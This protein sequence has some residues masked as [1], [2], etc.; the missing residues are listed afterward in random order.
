MT[1]WHLIHLGHLALS[2][3]ALL[4]IEATAVLPEGQVTFAEPNPKQPICGEELKTTFA[5]PPQNAHRTPKG[6][7]L[8]FQGGT[9]SNTEEE[10]GNESRKN[11]DHAHDDLAP[12]RKSLFFSADSE[13]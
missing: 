7:K 6:D 9:T 2:G 5:L 8:K 12:T 4:T 3:A 10:Q 1:D 11:R 13:F